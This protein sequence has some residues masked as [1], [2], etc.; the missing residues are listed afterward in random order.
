MQTITS[1]AGL[2]NAIQQL[3][4]EQ[5]VRGQL[6][7]KQFYL[8]YEGMK[9]VNL[10]NSTLK[11]VISSS[12]L[13]DNILGAALGLASG[14]ISKKIVVGTSGNIVRKLLGSILQLGIT[15]VVSQHSEG[16]KS[17]GQSVFQ[18]IFRRKEQIPHE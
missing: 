10:L 1:I 8:T 11:E 5:A 15:K 12:S 2:K 17:F 13:M 6:L 7:K 18:H 4:V 3:E 16:I 14:Y 9:P